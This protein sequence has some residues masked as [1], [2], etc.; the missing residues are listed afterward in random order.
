[1]ALAG[2]LVGVAWGVHVGLEQSGQ[3]VGVAEVEFC[4]EG[5]AGGEEGAYGGRCKTAAEKK[6]EKKTDT[7]PYGASHGCYGYPALR[8]F[9]GCFSGLSFGNRHRTRRTW[10]ELRVGHSGSSGL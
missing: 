1:M 7:F 4:G 3:V 6:K 5:G 8:L 9:Y 2:Q 10:S